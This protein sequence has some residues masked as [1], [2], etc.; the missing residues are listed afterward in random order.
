MFLAI[1]S[2]LGTSVA[3]VTL[4]G[5][6]LHEANSVDPRAHAERIGELLQECFD[7]TSYTYYDK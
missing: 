3:L 2:S 6:A 5:V 4:D 1:D 7:T